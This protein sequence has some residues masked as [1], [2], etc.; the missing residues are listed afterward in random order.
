MGYFNPVCSGCFTSST[1]TTFWLLTLFCS[2]SLHNCFF[3]RWGVK[4]I[5]TG[6]TFIRDQFQ[7]WPCELRNI[8][9]ALCAFMST[10]DQFY[11]LN[12][13]FYIVRLPTDLMGAS[14]V[15]TRKIELS[16]SKPW[17]FW[18]NWS[19]NMLLCFAYCSRH[20]PTRFLLF[21]LLS[22]ICSG[23][24]KIHCYQTKLFK[25]LSYVM[26]NPISSLPGR[27]YYVALDSVFIC[28]SAPN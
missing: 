5:V 12:T 1:F 26:T 15:L 22:N 23:L 16:Y 8:E 19:K 21:H 2:F 25:K 20:L 24:L 14:N 3:I 28:L 9:D 6:S 18:P 7:A 13:F 17:T 11:I 27:G 10:I 4:R